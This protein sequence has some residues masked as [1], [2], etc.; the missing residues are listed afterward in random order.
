MTTER[1]ESPWD[2]ETGLP[3]DVDGWISNPKFGLKDEYAEAVRAGG[4]A[5]EGTMFLVDLLDENGELIG[6]QGWSIGTGWIV[7]DDG[8]EITHPK[9]KNVVGSCLY[10]QL[11]N[12][13]RRELK[14][15]MEKFGPPTRARSWDGLGF[16]WMLLEHETVGAGPKPGLMPVEFLG[17]KEGLAAVPAGAPTRAPSIPA[18]LEMRLRTLAQ[19]N[20]IQAFQLAAVKMIEVV[21]SDELMARVLDG[22]PTG[23]WAQAQK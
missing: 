7:S 2:T 9:R 4:T 20:D 15:P 10:G 17:K 21:A 3:N 8:L 12:R 22:G 18:D 1:V 13:V 14:V 16:H 6:S 5:A 11:Q 23:Y 19:T